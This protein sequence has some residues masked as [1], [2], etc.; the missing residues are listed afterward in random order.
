MNVRF[1][2]AAAAAVF[3]VSA[4]PSTSEAGFARRDRAH[5]APVA[6]AP[7]AAAPARSCGLHDAMKRL[8][9][10]VAAVHTRVHDRV[11]A[12]RTH[13]RAERTAAAPAAAPA[14]KPLK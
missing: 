7:V 9:D 5:A 8:R 10:R 2:V 6:A 14:K 3:A 1:A 11:H 12:T 4:L 13:V